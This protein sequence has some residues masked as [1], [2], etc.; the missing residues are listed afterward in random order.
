MSN[1]AKLEESVRQY[2]TYIWN[3]PATADRIGG[4]NFDCVLRLSDIEIVIVEI[5][6]NSTLEKIRIDVAKIQTVRL[7]MMTNNIMLR[8]YIICDFT[9]TQGMKDAGKVNFIEVMSFSDFKNMFFDFPTYKNVRSNKQFGSCIDPLTGENDKTAYTPVGYELVN[10]GEVDAKGIA[11]RIIDNEKVILL[12]DYGTGKSRCFREVFHILSDRSDETLLYPI[13]IDL[14]ETWGLENAVEIIRRHFSHLGIGEKDT[15]SVIKAYN[16]KRL[17]FLLDG[18]DEIGSRPWSENKKTLELLR[19]HALLGVN[20]LLS[21]TGAG[22][23]ISGRDHYFNSNTEMFASFGLRETDVTLAKCKSEFSYDEFLKYLEINDIKVELPHWLPKKPLVLKTIAS[24]SKEQMAALF[25]SSNGDEIEFWFRFIDS[26]CERDSRIHAILDPETVKQ[27]L[28]KLSNLTRFKVQNVGPITETEVVNVFHEV[29]GTYP[30]EQSTVM[31]QRLPGLGRVSSE[32]GDRN[33]VDGFILDGLRALD[34]SS[35]IQINDKELPN[36]K[37]L[38]PLQHLGTSVLAYD[39]KKYKTENVFISYVKQS[40]HRNI[41]NKISISDAISSISKTD[42]KVVDYGSI[43][44]AEPYFGEISFDKNNISN[45]SFVDGVF[46]LVNLG[47][48]DPDNVIIKNSCI[49]KLKGVSSKT[50]V[51]TWITG[52]DISSY[53]S[54]DT[55]T[56]IKKSGLTNPQTILVSIL[57]KVYKQPGNGRLEHTLTKGLSH[58]DKKQLGQVIHFLVQSGYLDTSK[59]NGVVIYKP[60]RKIQARIDR[61]LVEL[62]RSTDEIWQYVSSL[63]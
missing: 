27:V 28:I 39:V 59:D 23:L 4:V 42:I 48:L 18:F 51:P 8:P 12:G 19:R 5:T 14:K 10:K 29:T 38:N 62:D 46:E 55:L 37:W 7:S 53:E 52:C 33:F 11:Q 30:N 56:A 21:N 41:P 44:F 16:G 3:R 26:M 50:G 58:V 32:T 24:L 17:C 40:I 34:L 31:L 20:D 43:V 1:W 2:S 47:K 9:P 22:F 13:A 54:I 36:S 60:V 63:V 57:I 49:E 25:E 61:I 15:N 45:I 6:E 35:R